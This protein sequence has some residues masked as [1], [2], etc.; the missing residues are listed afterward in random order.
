MGLNPM[1]IFGG[2]HKENVFDLSCDEVAEQL[3]T[4]V[5]LIWITHSTT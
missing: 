4:I 3:E 5:V 1:W 2:F